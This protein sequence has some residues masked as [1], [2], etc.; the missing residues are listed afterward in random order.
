LHFRR[1]LTHLLLVA[2]VLV[3]L[4]IIQAQT[5]PPARLVQSLAPVAAAVKAVHLPV[6]DETAAPVAVP[7]EPEPAGLA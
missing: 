5:V 4:E 1:L 3:L 7:P 2:E 6:T